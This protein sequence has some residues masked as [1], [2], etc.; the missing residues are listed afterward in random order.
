LSEKPDNV[1]YYDYITFRNT[2]GTTSTN[3]ARVHAWTS[4]LRNRYE[5]AFYTNGTKRFLPRA[6][7]EAFRVPPFFTC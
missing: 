3:N 2:D 4:T 5:Q 6:R 1:N 7:G